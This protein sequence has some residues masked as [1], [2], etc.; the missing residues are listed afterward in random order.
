MIDDVSLRSLDFLSFLI[1]FLILFPSPNVFMY[2][3][4]FP[5]DTKRRSH[6][7]DPAL[8][9]RLLPAQK[10]W[11]ENYNIYFFFLRFTIILQNHR[12]KLL[13]LQPA[14]EG[15]PG[16]VMSESNKHILDN[17]YPQWIDLQERLSKLAKPGP[18]MNRR[19]V[20]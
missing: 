7:T 19:V 9:A 11:L 5:I 6:P 16:Q 14:R 8:V 10:I 2:L 15:Q 18:G 4:F 13:L 12:R 20:I 1:I 17:V 3:H